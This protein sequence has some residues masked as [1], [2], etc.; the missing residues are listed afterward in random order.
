MELN[1]KERAELEFLRGFKFGVE[2]VMNFI[3]SSND[4]VI[5]KNIKV[6]NI[7]VKSKED[8]E[9][10]FKKMMEGGDF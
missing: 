2:K 7:E 5:N 10:F 8:F 1:N 3:D 6:E 9:K 4:D